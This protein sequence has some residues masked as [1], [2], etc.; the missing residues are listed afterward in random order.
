MRVQNVH[1]HAALL[2]QV[3]LCISY[4][5]LSLLQGPKGI[6]LRE[7]AFRKPIMDLEIGGAPL[8][9]KYQTGIVCYRVFH[10]SSKIECFVKR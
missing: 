2:L 10:F 6:H 1:V 7:Q 4:S 3:L 8:Q 5:L 9:V